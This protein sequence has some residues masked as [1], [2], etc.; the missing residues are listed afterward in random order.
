MFIV[1]PLCAEVHRLAANAFSLAPG[2][3]T[4]A[5]WQVKGGNAGAPAPDKPGIGPKTKRM[6]KAWMCGF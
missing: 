1:S 5:F 2:T 4:T 6:R 3:A